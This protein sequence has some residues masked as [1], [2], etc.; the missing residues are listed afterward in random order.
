M[1]QTRYKNSRRRFLQK[2]MVMGAGLL[3]LSFA[4]HQSCLA[5]KTTSLRLGGPVFEDYKSPEQ[6]AENLKSLGY[7][8]ADYIRSIGTN[9]GLSIGEG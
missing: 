4:P 1:E 3:G 7:R 5:A 6:W 9:M 8:A 2:S